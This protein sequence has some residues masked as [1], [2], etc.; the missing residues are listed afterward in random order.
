MRWGSSRR[1]NFGHVRRG[2]LGGI[3]FSCLEHMEECECN[4]QV[5][6][7]EGVGL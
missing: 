5:L 7:R 1:V 6:M 4:E 2:I 3:I